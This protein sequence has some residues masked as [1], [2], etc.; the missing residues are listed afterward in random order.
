MF[1]SKIIPNLLLRVGNKFN[2]IFFLKD[3]YVK[4]HIPKWWLFQLFFQNAFEKRSIEIE[5]G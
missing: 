1:F 5:I 4:Q 3:A 2:P